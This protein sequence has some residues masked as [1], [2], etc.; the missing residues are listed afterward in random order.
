MT[1]LLETPAPPPS[2]CPWT[3]ARRDGPPSLWWSLVRDLR[4]R[5]APA[6]RERGSDRHRRAASLPGPPPAVVPRRGEPPFRH[7]PVRHR[8]GLGRARTRLRAPGLPALDRHRRRLPVLDAKFFTWSMRNIVGEKGGS[9]TPSSARCS[10]PAPRGDLG[11]IGLLTAIYLVEYGDRSGWRSSIRFL[12]DVM[13]GSPPS[14]PACSP[15]RCSRVLRAR[16]AHGSRRRRR[17]LV[18]DDPDRGPLRLGDA[19]ARPADLR[20]AS[21]ALG[22]PKW[23]PIVK[24]VLPTAMAGSSPASRSPSPASSARPLRC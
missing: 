10:S 1:T 3:R 15:T 5:R 12:V 11:P 2:T 20:E 8:L 18:V 24:I 6:G 14:S 23:Q 22:V 9:T 21:Y 17:A 19:Q 4:A 7:G 13:T 16:R